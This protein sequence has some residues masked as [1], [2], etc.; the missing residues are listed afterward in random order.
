[1]RLLKRHEFLDVKKSHCKTKMN[2]F[3]GQPKSCTAAQKARLGILTTRKLG[4]AH[5]R[6]KARRLIR[7]LFRNNYS[8]IQNGT[9]LVILPRR[10]IFEIKYSFLEKEFITFLGKLQILK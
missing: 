3:W 1:M 10:K 5:V 4:P 2:L 6:N 9:M 8:L 7:E